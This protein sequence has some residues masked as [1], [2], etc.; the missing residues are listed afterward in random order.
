[1][2]LVATAIYIAALFGAGLWFIH[3]ERSEQACEVTESTSQSG[4]KR[5]EV[6]RP[7]KRDKKQEQEKV[8]MSLT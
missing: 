5:K 2:A 8:A 6:D 1:M 7:D 3:K 4:S